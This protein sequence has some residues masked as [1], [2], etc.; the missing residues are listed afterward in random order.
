[1]GF[2]D[3]FNAHRRAAKKGAGE[4]TR[5]VGGGAAKAGKGVKKPVERNSAIGVK[6][7]MEYNAVCEL[8]GKY[9]VEPQ[10]KP[11]KQAFGGLFGQDNKISGEKKAEGCGKYPSGDMGRKFAYGSGEMAPA[12]VFD[13]GRHIGIYEVL[14]W[15]MTLFFVFFVFGKKIRLCR[16]FKVHANGVNFC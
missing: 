12:L 11:L 9:R 10:H 5:C 8:G 2:A 16:I 3:I 1:M 14:L 6:Q 7:D 4:I 13:N 15:V